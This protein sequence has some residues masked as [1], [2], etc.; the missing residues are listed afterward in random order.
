[1]GTGSPSSAISAAP[2]YNTKLPDKPLNSTD[3]QEQLNQ[4][5]FLP[6]V[7]QRAA[8]SILSNRNVLTTGIRGCPFLEKT[9]GT[10]FYG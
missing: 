6:V 9:M 10:Q 2:E 7:D 1:M 8:R 3:M 5:Y 4:Y